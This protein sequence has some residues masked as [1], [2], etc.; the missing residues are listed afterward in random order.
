MRRIMVYPYNYNP[1]TIFPKA[2]IVVKK[3]NRELKDIIKELEG[4]IEY[5]SN[6]FYLHCLKYPM[7]N[8]DGLWL[9]LNKYQCEDLVLH[10]K[11]KLNQNTRWLNE[12]KPPKEIKAGLTDAQIQEAREYP[13]TE[14]VGRDRQIF[15]NGMKRFKAICPFHKDSHPSMVLYEES[16][17]YYCFVCGSGGDT[18]KYI[19]DYLKLDFIEAVKNILTIT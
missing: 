4:E 16:N 6:Q 7:Y 5:Y 9:Q 1:L 13:I 17:S 8:E 12:L 10:F 18:I 19:M 15:K 3:Q 11:K 2:I 14:L